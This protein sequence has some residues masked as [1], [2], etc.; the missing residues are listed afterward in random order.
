MESLIYGNTNTIMSLS[1][2]NDKNTNVKSN[3]ELDYHCGVTTTTLLTLLKK[4]YQA[5]YDT[6]GISRSSSFFVRQVVLLLS[7]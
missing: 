6:L 2:L 4:D 5:N 7:P 3:Q 1:G